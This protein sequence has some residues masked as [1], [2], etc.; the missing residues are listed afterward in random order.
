MTLFKHGLIKSLATTLLL[1]SA[2]SAHSALITFGDDNLDRLDLA[3]AQTEDGFSYTATG[4]G[5]ELQNT[6][7]SPGASL[8]TFFN[9]EGALLGDSISFVHTAGSLFSFD[10]IDWRSINMNGDNDHVLI[11]GFNGGALVDSLSI[12]GV[13]TSFSTLTGFGGL[14]D[15]LTITISFDGPNALLFDNLALTTVTSNAIPEP[16]IGLLMLLGAAALVRRQAR[17]R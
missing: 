6:F 8:A 11:E 12:T 4:E 14:L 7:G 13:N 3:G 2:F 1:F 9:V 15:A 16:Q 10:A 17:R 5:W